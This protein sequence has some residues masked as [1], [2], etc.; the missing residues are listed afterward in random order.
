[1][2]KRFASRWS[3]VVLALVFV[4]VASTANR[5]E[6]RPKYKSAFEKMYPKVGEGRKRISCSLCHLARDDKKQRNHYGDA[7]AKELGKKPVKDVKDEKSIEEALKA[8]ED[9][10][11]KSGKWKERLDKGLAPCVCNSNDHDPDSY[12]GRLLESHR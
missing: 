2:S 1:M 4:F 5:G 12:I 3:C 7:L 8:I 9:G 6:A 10:E 11:C